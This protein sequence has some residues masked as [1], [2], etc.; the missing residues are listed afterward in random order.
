MFLYLG[1]ETDGA[2]GGTGIAC[3]RGDLYFEVPEIKGKD[4]Y[5]YDPEDPSIHVIDMSE[6]ELEVPEERIR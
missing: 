1:E 6:N 4:S 3:G 5:L 2:A